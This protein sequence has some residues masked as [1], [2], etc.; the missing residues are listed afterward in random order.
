MDNLNLIDS[1]NTTTLS[2]SVLQ[3]TALVRFAAPI[4]SLLS[5]IALLHYLMIYIFAEMSAP[6]SK[7][8]SFKL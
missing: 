3:F 1:P 7:I 4:L 8:T 5:M 2:D 6:A